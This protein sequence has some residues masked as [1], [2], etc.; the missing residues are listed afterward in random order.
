[1][2]FERYNHATSRYNQY[3][4]HRCVVCPPTR[5]TTCQELVWT[6]SALVR[7]CSNSP[8]EHANTTPV[9]IFAFSMMVGLENSKCHDHTRSGSIDESFVLLEE[10]HMYLA[11]GVLQMTTVYYK[12]F[13]KQ[14]LRCSGLLV[15]EFFFGSRW[16]KVIRDILK[17][18]AL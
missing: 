17:F 15:F 9:G 3:S 6:E 16:H 13:R 1:M 18:R 12:S 14:H 7:S 10:P 5:L 4:P 11:G 2:G 8:S